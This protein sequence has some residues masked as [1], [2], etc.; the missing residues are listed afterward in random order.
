M[1]VKVKLLSID[2]YGKLKLSRKVLLK[3]DS[4]KTPNKKS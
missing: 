4:E 3:K 2:E 1:K